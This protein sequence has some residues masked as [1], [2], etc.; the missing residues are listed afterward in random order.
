MRE[1]SE[2]RSGEPGTAL[3]LLTGRAREYLSA[4]RAPATLRAYRSDWA[5]FSSWALDRGLATMPAAPS[6][7]VLYLTDL[8][9]LAKTS[10]MARRLASI[11]SAHKAAGHR[12]PTDDPGVKA[13]WA[14][15]RRTHGSAPE[16][17]AP[18]SVAL[19]RRMIDTAPP[20][21]GGL[22]DRALLLVGFAGALRRSELVALDVAD[23]SERDEGQVIV[24]RRSKTDQEGAGREVGIPYGSNPSTCPVRALRSWLEQ[25]RV[26]E[27]PLFRP[28][29]RHGK[30]SPADLKSLCLADFSQKY[31]ISLG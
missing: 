11:S 10:T 27:G 8:A 2:D 9:G 6:T 4:A 23:I 29:D 16:E 21:L 12:S 25:S 3:E 5:E 19:L 1:G 14:G 30:L 31:G 15:I 20:G 7:V 22:R 26:T 13:V 17:A 18:I 28:V 24:L